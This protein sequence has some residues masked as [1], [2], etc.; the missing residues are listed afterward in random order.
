M[1]CHHRFSS[2]SAIL[3]HWTTGLNRLTR[4][5]R[6]WRWTVGTISG[7]IYRPD[8][9]TGGAFQ[10]TCT[11]TIFT[12]C[13]WFIVTNLCRGIAVALQET[14]QSRDLPC[15][16]IVYPS[17]RAVVSKTV[18]IWLGEDL[19]PSRY[20]QSVVEPRKKDQS[21]VLCHQ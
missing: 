9:M 18:S 13:Y 3:L 15:E 4:K 1:F 10:F 16:V 2:L 11:F 5:F 8:L 20:K 7:C 12:L 19:H 17:I 21:L 6:P 14:T